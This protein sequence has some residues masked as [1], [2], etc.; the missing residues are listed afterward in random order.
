MRA[1]NRTANAKRYTLEY[2]AISKLT[3][4]KLSRLCTARTLP[5]DIHWLAQLERGLD[6]TL[7]YYPIYRANSGKLF[8]TDDEVLNF[9]LHRSFLVQ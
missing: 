9:I 3:D 5:A 7:F 8:P 4:Y 1:I 6:A 2:Y